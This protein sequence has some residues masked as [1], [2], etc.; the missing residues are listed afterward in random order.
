[1]I[2]SVKKSI[3]Y[4]ESKSMAMHLQASYVEGFYM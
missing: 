3:F 1:M 2:S 4:P